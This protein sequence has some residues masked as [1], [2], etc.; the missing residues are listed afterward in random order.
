VHGET[1]EVDL[2]E[3]FGRAED[4]LSL[5]IAETGAEVTHDPLPVLHGDATQLGMLMQNMLS[6]AIKFR[7]PDRPPKVH[8]S[9]WR[10]D[11]HWAFACADNGIGIEPEFAERVF[12]IFQRLHTRDA[13]PGN[14]IGLALCKKVVEFHGGTIGIDP[15]HAPG[16][17]ITFTLSEP[18]VPAVLE[19]ARP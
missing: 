15:A 12:V 14:G 2:E 17:R 5:A 19:A 1:A 6:N 16:A 13:Y 18:A 9:A 7:S 4:A 10:E 11:D 8:L 3:V